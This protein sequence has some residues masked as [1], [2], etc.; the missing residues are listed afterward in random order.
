METLRGWLSSSSFFFFSLYCITPPIKTPKMTTT[1]TTR[2]DISSTSHHSWRLSWLSQN[3]RTRVI[4]TPQEPRQPPLR[5]Y[6]CLYSEK[7]HLCC[8]YIE[9][10][11]TLFGLVAPSVE[12][13][14]GQ[15]ILASWAMFGHSAVWLGIVSN[16]HMA[17]ILGEDTNNR[18]AKNNPKKHNTKKFKWRSCR[19]NA[20]LTLLGKVRHTLPFADLY[21]E[22][23]YSLL[24]SLFHILSI[25]PS[26]VIF[27]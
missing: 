13:R 23:S 24:Y 17:L 10:C 14:K 18:T 4:E 11:K 8:T 1:P 27:H 25:S 19:E 20:L 12:G 16:I 2:P 5:L 26:N 9:G 22:A 3:E 15:T 7:F 6:G 21:F